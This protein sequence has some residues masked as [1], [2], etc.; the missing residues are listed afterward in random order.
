MNK[1]I[2]KTIKLGAVA[3]GLSTALAMPSWL[4]AENTDPLTVTAQ[5]FSTYIVSGF[6]TTLS[7]P[8]IDVTETGAISRNLA[9]N[10]TITSAG[11]S[12]LNLSTSVTDTDK[13][14]KDDIFVITKDGATPGTHN[15]IPV[16]LTCN[17]CNKGAS[18]LR[19]ETTLSP[20]SSTGEA[21]SYSDGGTVTVRSDSGGDRV[22]TLND[23]IAGTAC[24]D[25]TACSV[26]VMP[27]NS[28][29]GYARA[30]LQASTNYTGKIDIT[31]EQPTG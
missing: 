30:S 19:T 29:D 15:F 11:T 18:S 24:A 7:L 13:N 26:T 12:G 25:L 23:A 5:V 1:N 8:N 16:K 2:N 9:G 10:Q 17:I 31:A 20:I 21:G 27:D 6:G 28:V 14:L 4:G 3:L 22:L